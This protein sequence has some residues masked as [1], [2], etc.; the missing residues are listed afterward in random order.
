M[1][2]TI[3]VEFNKYCGKWCVNI[4]VTANTYCHV[5]EWPD[6]FWIDDRI[7][8]TL[9]Y[10]AWQH[11]TVHYDTSVH[12]PD[13]TSRCLVAASNGE[14]S[15]S[16][17]LP[18]CPRPH[19]TATGHSDWNVAVLELTHQSNPSL[20]LLTQVKVTLQLTFSQLVC[21]GVEPHLGLMTRYFFYLFFVKVA[22]LSI[23]GALSDERTGLS[24]VS[25]S[26]EVGRLSVYT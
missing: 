8:W 21:L 26:L 1:G 22:V 5:T 2:S 13:F 9:W 20:K 16:S 7:Y 17:G 18:N 24:F 25:Q 11:F 23:W 10:S 15:P 14:R 19:L 3:D 12:S 4:S 6:G